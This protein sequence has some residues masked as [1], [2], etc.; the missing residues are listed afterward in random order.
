MIAPCMAPDDRASARGSN[1][2]GMFHGFL[3]DETVRIIG[4]VG[5]A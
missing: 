2:I 3:A 1:A 4:A 5:P